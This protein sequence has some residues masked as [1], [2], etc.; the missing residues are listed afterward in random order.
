MV[1]VVAASA[2]GPGVAT[3]LGGL[4]GLVVNFVLLGL[5]S[6]GAGAGAAATRQS[7]VKN[8]KKETFINYQHTAYPPP[9]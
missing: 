7:M 6:V 9:G 2:V 4:G 5:D 1:V 8:C 3:S